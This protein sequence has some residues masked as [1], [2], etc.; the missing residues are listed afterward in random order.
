[1]VGVSNV[2]GFLTSYA[3]LKRD[4]IEVRKQVFGEKTE[5][6]SVAEMRRV[7]KGLGKKID[8]FHEMT[9]G[10]H[11][12]YT[13]FSAIE[14]HFQKWADWRHDVIDKEISG[15]AL[16]LGKLEDEVD[17]LSDD[18]VAVKKKNGS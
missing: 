1:V 10:E 7:L 5:D 9:S 3:F 18:L 4:M 15:L 12:F 13:K 2:V 16:K 17:D 11:G 8:D 6:A 14:L